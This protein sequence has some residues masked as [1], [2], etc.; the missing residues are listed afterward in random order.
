MAPRSQRPTLHS[1]LSSRTVPD[2]ARSH[3]CELDRNKSGV[4]KCGEA[5]LAVRRTDG[6]DETAAVMDRMQP[7]A[8]P[9]PPLLLAA[10]RS[11]RPNRA[12]PRRPCRS[13]PAI[14]AA[15]TRPIPG[16]IDLDIDATDTTR[17]VLPGDADRSRCPP[18]E[19]ELILL[20]P[21]MAARQSR[22][23]RADQPDLPTS[24]SRST[25]SRAEWTRDP[26]EVYAFRIAAARRR[27]RG[28]R[29]VRPHLAAADQRRA[30]HDD[31]A[32]CSTCSGRR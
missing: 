1:R 27:A 2:P 6:C 10:R 17:G 18:G 25:A 24:A 21:A 29:E 8:S 31:A 4:T 12:P 11:P 22:P 15:R 20:L 7:L 19:R 5:R 23:A 26:V 16:T 13:P 3:G 30:D 32:K 9:C 28:H 14:P